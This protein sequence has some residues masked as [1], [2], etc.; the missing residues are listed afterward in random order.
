MSRF[1]RALGFTLAVILG[2]ALVMG[3]IWW[4]LV[5]FPEESLAIIAGSFIILIF[6]M[7]YVGLGE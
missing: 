1:F 2:V 3:Y 7:F 6:G 4:I 5:T